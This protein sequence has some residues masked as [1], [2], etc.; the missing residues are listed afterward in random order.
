MYVHINQHTG[1]DPFDLIGYFYWGG[2]VAFLLVSLVTLWLVWN[3]K[4]H[5]RKPLARQSLF[6]FLWPFYLVRNVWRW[7]RA[8]AKIAF[9]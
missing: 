3:D 9:Q 2:C 8:L 1:P 5:L 6:F 7:G 4:P